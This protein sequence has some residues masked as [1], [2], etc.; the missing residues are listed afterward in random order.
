MLSRAVGGP[1]KN[2]AVPESAN[3]IELRNGAGAGTYTSRAGEKP[4]ASAALVVVK[5]NSGIV[6]L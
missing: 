2:Q 6:R 5:H 3:Q 4:A 1:E